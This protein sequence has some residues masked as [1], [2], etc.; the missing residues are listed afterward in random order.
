MVRPKHLV[1]TFVALMMGYVLV[2]NERFLIESESPMWGHFSKYGWWILTH[3]VAGA[4]AMFLAPFQFSDRLRKRY[5]STHHLVGYIYVVGILILAPL[6]I[7]VQY[8]SETLDGTPRSFTVL[9][10]VDAVML[11]ITTGVALVFARQ[12]RLT[13]HRQWMTRSYA[14]ALVFFEGRLILGLTGLETADITIVQAVIWSCLALSVP[15]ADV[16]NDWAELRRTAT[17][18]VRSPRADAPAPGAL[19]PSA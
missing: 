10:T 12:R 9:A 14:V 13:L 2:H 5:T 6:G 17:V 8:I 15:V 7:Y 19:A 11:Y 16:I 1:F 4:A 18:A 3:G